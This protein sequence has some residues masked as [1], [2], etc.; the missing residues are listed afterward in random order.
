MIDMAFTPQINEYRGS[1]SVQLVASAVR[2]HDPRE[3]CDAILHGEPGFEW[4]G[5][6]PP[7]VRS[8]RIS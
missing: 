3:L 2:R 1:V 7:I 6:P 4:A 5:Q 8:G